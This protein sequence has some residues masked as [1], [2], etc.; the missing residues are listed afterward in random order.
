LHS[1]LDGTCYPRGIASV[2]VGAGLAPCGQ[3]PIALPIER[4]LFGAAEL[5]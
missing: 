1:V 4:F 2:A 5:L 3:T